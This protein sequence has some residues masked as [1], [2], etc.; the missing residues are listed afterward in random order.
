M[1]SGQDDATLP[2]EGAQTARRAL[3]LLEALAT[4]GVDQRLDELASSVGLSKST[5][6][7]LL[8]VLEEELYVEH[9][10]YGYRLGSRLVGLAAAA[11]PEF[12]VYVAVRP[13]L[14][15]L[16]RTTGE[17]VTLHRRVG[18]LSILVL[19]EENEEQPLRRVARVGEASPLVRGAVGLSI[20]AL[21]DVADAEQ[22][23]E[24]SVPESDRPEL[25]AVLLDIRAAGYVL[26]HGA[27]HPGVSGVAATIP[28]TDGRRDATSIAIS[29]PSFRWTEDRMRGVA[30]EL[31][32]ACAEL[33]TL[34]IQGPAPA[35][36]VAPVSST[37]Q[38]P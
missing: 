8:R 33:A 35:F 20:L 18:D 2:T 38:R 1:A 19:G 22:V 23:I 29:G 6:Y 5:A 4:S 24:R 11:L 15:Q 31:T 10:A 13:T 27:N 7:R 17:T 36:Q 30:G 28:S 26:S 34:F 3:R 9:T 25:A 21:L 14:R 16:A 12:D 32:E 37:G